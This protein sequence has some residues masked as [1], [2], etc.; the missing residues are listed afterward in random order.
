MP[1]ASNS[2]KPL[3]YGGLKSKLNYFGKALYENGARLLSD[4]KVP[5]RNGSCPSGATL[6]LIRSAHPARNDLLRT[7]ASQALMSIQRIKT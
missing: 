4:A 5:F 6:A 7:I 3:E 2:Q 1:T